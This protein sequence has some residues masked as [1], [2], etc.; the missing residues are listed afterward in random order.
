M[1]MN[2][3]VKGFSAL[4]Q[5]TRLETIRL[6]VREGPSGLMAGVIAERLG[7]S[8]STLS[9]HLNVLDNAGLVCS[10]RSTRHIF[11]A[12]NIDGLR[13]LVAFL[14]EDCCQGNP[15]ICGDLT[16]AKEFCKA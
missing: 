16:N 9:H 5:G 15:D 11:Y 7:V 14:T 8:P 1:E 12:A 10:W 4:A 3:A 13:D 6:L 2:G